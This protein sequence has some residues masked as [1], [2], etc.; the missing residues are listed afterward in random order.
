MDPSV[1]SSL[2]FSTISSWAY[3]HQRGMSV[4]TSNQLSPGE[5]TWFHRGP[6]S[7]LRIASWR[8]AIFLVG[9]RSSKQ[10]CHGNSS[11]GLGIT[12]RN[13]CQGAG[14][15]GFW[16]V[17]IT[18]STQG[19]LSQR[20]SIFSFIPSREHRHLDCRNW[21]CQKHKSGPNGTETEHLKKLP[22]SSLTHTEGDDFKGGIWGPFSW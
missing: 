10:H 11:S 14:R 6:I 9:W 2:L 19:T 5:P 18:A 21:L 13:S 15:A 1:F 20:A 3:L 22:S 8:K 17:P 16:G 7:C 4:S 12:T